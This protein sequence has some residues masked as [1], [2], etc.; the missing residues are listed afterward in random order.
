MQCPQCQRENP[1]QAKFCRGCGHRFTPRCAQCG[2]ELAPNDQFCMECGTPVA[3][4]AGAQPRP[5]D[6]ASRVTSPQ[7]YTPQHIAER[8]LT[9]RSALEGERKQVTVLFADLKGSMELLADRDP[10]EARAILDPVLE[11]MMEAVHRYEGTVNQVMGD[12]IMALFGAPVAHEDHAVRACYAALRMQEAVKQYAQELQR[13][14]GAF[15]QIRVGLNSGEVVVRSI[16]SDLRMDYTAVGQT[17]HLAARMEQIAMPGSTL[18]APDT[19]LLVEGYV[20]ARALGPMVVKG[21]GEPVEVYELTGAGVARS[22]LQAAT[23][24]GLTQFVGRDAELE[25]LRRTLDQAGRGHGQLVALVGEPGVGKSRLVWEFSHSHRTQGWLLL[26][27]GS[28]SYG[29]A[30]SYLPLID[31]LKG[32]C[33]IEDLDDPRRM[34]EKVAGKVLMLDDALRSSLPALLAL[35]DLPVDDAEWQTL[36]P[37]QRRQRTHEALKRLLLRESVEQPLLLVLEDLHW[38]DAETQALLDSLVERLPTSRILLLV[39][40]RPE[41]EHTWHSKT[42]YQQLR[43]DPLPPES[44]IELLT[45]L[46]GD[47]AELESLRRMLIKGTEG[48]PFFVEESVRS[49]VESGTLVGERGAYRLAKPIESAQVPATVQ[50]VLAAR[51][52]RL[53]PEDKRL[54]QSAAVIGKDVPYQVLR[55]IAE[56]PEDVLHQGLGRLHRAEFLYETSLYPEAEFTFKHALTQEVTYRSMLQERR[57]ALHARVVDALE[58]RFPD[59]LTEQVERLGYHALRGE[60][61][62]K[63]VRYLSQAGLKA[64]A[65]A[66]HAEAIAALRLALESLA[67]LAKT[68]EN[69]ETAIDLRFDLRNSL[70]VSGQADQILHC[71][72]EAERIAMQ[73]DDARRLGRCYA[74]MGAYAWWVGDPK[75]GIDV[76]SRAAAIGRQTNDRGLVVEALYRAGLAYLALGEYPR[77]IDSLHHEIEMLSRDLLNEEFGAA[78]SPIVASRVWLVACL[79]EIGDFADGILVGEEAARIAAASEHPAR[80]AGTGHTLGLLYARKGDF[81]LAIRVL[82]RARDQCLRF[83]MRFTL[84]W[85]LVELGHTYAHLG[86]IAEAVPLVDEALAVNAAL[87]RKGFY[88]SYFGAQVAQ[89]YLLAGRTED[90]LDLA[91]EALAA[92]REYHERGNEAWALRLLGEIAVHANPPDTV[93]AETHY[94]QALALADELGMRPL[95]AHCHLGLGTLYQRIGHGEQSRA[96]LDAAAEMYRAMEMTF[97]LEKA[98]AALARGAD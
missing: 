78:M 20:Q 42:Y 69:L 55:V 72:Q 48:N 8:I 28:V 71:L 32:Y 84:P 85:S 60:L 16:G 57:R 44:A 4:P 59:R 26:D 30:T 23:S 1:P 56:L 46:L 34:R 7:T 14:E 25:M 81:D 68:R 67:H 13:T 62:N 10:E 36:G 95:V 86:R 77:A 98:E 21:L 45:V 58:T 50:A 90:A 80:L 64:Q 87:K 54:L 94:R 41:Y 66:A 15:I 11:R 9:S 22:R 97:W 61:W 37:P 24:R 65:R 92:A 33:G 19:L 40:Y 3:P 75:R 74:L 38:I 47:S 18:L 6:G 93:E 5:A 79:L 82:E 27:S 89:T 88:H 17:T 29:Q 91:M 39:S 51:I 70:Y 31:L 12:G 35:L 2:T 52:D 96:E 83:N 49:L 53:A 63:A 43:L 76:G 73:L